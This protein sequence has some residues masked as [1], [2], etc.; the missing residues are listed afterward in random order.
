MSELFLG[1][2]T[3]YINYI[4]FM[5]RQVLKITLISQT[6]SDPPGINNKLPNGFPIKGND[7]RYLE[8]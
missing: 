3:V 4:N 6:C 1:T 7:Q 8:K 5:V 2:I